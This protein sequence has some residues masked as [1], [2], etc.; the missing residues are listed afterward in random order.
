MRAQVAI[1]HVG[2]SC[3]SELLEVGP[4]S[5]ARTGVPGVDVAIRKQVGGFRTNV[6]YGSDHALGQAAFDCEVPALRVPP[7]NL[8]FIGAPH[9]GDGRQTH[10][11]RREVWTEDR[12]NPL[13]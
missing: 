8:P 13:I 9:V 10:D 2:S 7:V 6:S 11:T 12:R 3:A 4:A 1:P 5:L